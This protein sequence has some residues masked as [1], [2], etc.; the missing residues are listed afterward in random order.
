[1]T[2]DGSIDCQD[3]PNE[4]EGMVSHLHYCEAVSS[5]QFDSIYL[6]LFMLTLVLRPQLVSSILI[7]SNATRSHDH[8]ECCLVLISH[9][10]PGECYQFVR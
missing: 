6:S 8:M 2:A 4:Q 9:F 1:M 5:S 10:L 7:E 3:N